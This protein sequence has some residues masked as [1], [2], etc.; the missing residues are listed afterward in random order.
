[1]SAIPSRRRS[2][3]RGERSRWNVSMMAS[4]SDLAIM[5][6]GSPFV[7]VITTVTRSSTAASMN[8]FRF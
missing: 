2:A 7:R 8:D 5:I 6:T 3:L 4:Y 1:M